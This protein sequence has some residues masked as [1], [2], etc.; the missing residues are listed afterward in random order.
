MKKV[1]L[2]A[3]GLVAM[4]SCETEQTE[5]QQGPVE[6]VN[7]ASGILDGAGEENIPK[8]NIV[9]GDRATWNALLSQMNSVNNETDNFVE[10]EVDF[11]SFLVLAS[12]D[13]VKETGGF[14][15]QILE[16]TQNSSDL[17][18]VILETQPAEGDIVPM[19]VTQPYNIVKIL[20]TYTPII[21]E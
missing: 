13:E 18:V 7:L 14:D 5:L 21:F 12:F 1:V 2:I 11:E 9:I 3:I 20:R 4:L 6:V 15:I 16:A 10:T 19:V 8:Q 17:S